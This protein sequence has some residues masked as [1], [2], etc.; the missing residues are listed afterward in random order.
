MQINGLTWVSSHLFFVYLRRTRCV[1]YKRTKSK[2][3]A[4]SLPL[5]S[6][7]FKLTVDDEHVAR[8]LVYTLLYIFF[9]TGALHILGQGN[10]QSQRGVMSNS[11]RAFSVLLTAKPGDSKASEVAHVTYQC[12][13]VWHFQESM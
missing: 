12:R 6:G 9:G 2:A 11:L 3:I 13:K 5:E 10:S 4:H 1:L 7:K 8:A